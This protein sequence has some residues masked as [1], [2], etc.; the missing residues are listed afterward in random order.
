MG[1]ISNKTITIL[2]ASSII[3]SFFAI[4]MAENSG[5][6][7][8]RVTLLHPKYYQAQDMFLLSIF[9]AV[10]IALNIYLIFFYKNGKKG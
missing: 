10:L 7:T 5:E 6:M 4:I 2:T 1:T 3:V 8:G 9:A